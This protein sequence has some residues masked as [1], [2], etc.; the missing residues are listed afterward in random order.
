KRNL[1]KNQKPFSQDK[2]TEVMELQTLTIKQ[3]DAIA[4]ASVSGVKMNYKERIIR[5]P[6]SKDLPSL[7]PSRLR[8]VSNFVFFYHWCRR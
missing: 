7:M 5:L 3:L 8:E 6:K 4:D 1:S 2:S